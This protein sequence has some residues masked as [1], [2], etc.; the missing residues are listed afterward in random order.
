MVALLDVS[1]TYVAE[2]RPGATEKHNSPGFRMRTAVITTPRGPYFLKFVGPAATIA[3]WDTGFNQFLDS[4]KFEPVTCRASLR[5]AEPSAETLVRA[6][7][8]WTARR[9]RR[10]RSIATRST[11]G[12]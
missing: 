10:G 11:R 8:S 3:A 2:M 5:R 6:G 1:G 9:H 4:L 7:V 12:R